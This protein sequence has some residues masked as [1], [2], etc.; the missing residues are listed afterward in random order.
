MPGYYFD[1]VLQYQ[2]PNRAAQVGTYLDDFRA[3]ARGQALIVDLPGDPSRHTVSV[4]DPRHP[5]GC[6]SQIT[7][8][9]HLR[10]PTFEELQDV[11]NEVENAIYHTD[12]DCDSYFGMAWESE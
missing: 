12:A 4:I 2:Q 11:R 5:Q 10:A 1:A 3:S 8:R 7:M 9:Y 6:R